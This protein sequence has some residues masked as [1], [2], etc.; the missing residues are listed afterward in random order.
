LRR[1][2]EIAEFVGKSQSWVKSTLN[3]YLSPESDRLSPYADDSPRRTRD[4][5]KQA[6]R[7]QTESVI[8]DLTDDEA[9]KVA[10]AHWSAL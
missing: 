6:L 8:E 10:E 4:A 1:T 9:A 5:A 2:F 7:E 3:W